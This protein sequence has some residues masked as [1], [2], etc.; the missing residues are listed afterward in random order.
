MITDL[1]DLAE[2]LGTEPTVK[3]VA[4]RIFK[5]TECG[6]CFSANE[7][8]VVV[9]GY[10]EGDVGDCPSYELV[11]PFEEKTFDETLESCDSDADVLWNETHGCEHC[12]FEVDGYIPVN[13]NCN[14]CH[15]GGR[16]I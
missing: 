3:S 4:H 13:P 11:F 5:D 1:K 14:H 12:G 7:T 15:G 6:A 10:V 16:V 8:K 9:S 2:Y